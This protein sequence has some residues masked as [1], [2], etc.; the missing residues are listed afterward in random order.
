MFS[1]LVFCHIGFD[2][3]GGDG[4]HGTTN[5]WSAHDERRRRVEVGNDI[6]ACGFVKIF[7]T[8]E[9]LLAVLFDFDEQHIAAPDHVAHD[10][11]CADTL[12][13]IVWVERQFRV[14]VA[15]IENRNRVE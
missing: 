5:R 7:G 12:L 4:I 3:S 1:P 13:R 8:A 9:Y 11:R 2:P 14:A 15:D 6:F 10:A